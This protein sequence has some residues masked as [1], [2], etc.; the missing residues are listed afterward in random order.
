MTSLISIPAYLWRNTLRRW[1][2]NPASPATKFLVPF[3]FGLLALLVLGLLRGVEA[4]LN[5]QLA[6]SDLR[7]ISVSEFVTAEEAENR[8]YAA[9]EHRSQWADWCKSNDLLLQAP[10]SASSSFFERMPVIAYIEPP[11]FIPLPE[12]K[13]GG[14]RPALILSSLPYTEN[15]AAKGDFIEVAEAYRIPA[16]LAPMPSE[17]ATVFQTKAIALVPAEMLE[18]ALTRAHTRLQILIPRDDVSPQRLESLIRMHAEAE[19]NDLRIFSAQAILEQLD[20]ITRRQEL[21]RVLLG[22]GIA[23]ILSLILGSLSLLE[24]RQEIYLFALLRSFGVRRI[25]L[26]IHYLL[27]TTLVTFSGGLAAIWVARQIIPY[28]ISRQEGATKLTLPFSIDAVSASDF[29]ILGIALLAGVVLSAL[30]L[31]PGLR[32]PAGLMLP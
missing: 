25:N 13:P 27:E 14:P 7:S 31:L 17:F 1:L 9:L 29:A 23:I 22:L 5:N 8:Y 26:F 24:F 32:R 10:L 16:E 2:E 18:L 21:A 3:L 11:S 4:E 12:S 28:L 6:R 30:P 19:D 20:Q 15:F